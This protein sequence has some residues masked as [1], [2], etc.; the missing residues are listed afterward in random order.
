VLIALVFQ[1]LER[2][3]ASHPVAFMLFEHE[4]VVPIPPVVFVLIVTTPEFPDIPL[5][6]VAAE[7]VH[8]TIVVCPHPLYES[9]NNAT[10]TKLYLMSVFNLETIGVIPCIVL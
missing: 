7:P 5:L 1:H 4:V 10:K 8:A 3:P 6:A 9:N 2:D